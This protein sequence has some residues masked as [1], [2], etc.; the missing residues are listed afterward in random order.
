MDDLDKY[1][2]EQKK[3]PEFAEIWE[4]DQFEY[5]L[6]CML[7]AARNEQDMSQTELAKKSGIRQS[8]ISRIEQGATVPSL[9]TLNRLA[10]GL[11][12]KLQISFV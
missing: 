5:D 3:D 2:T 11:G 6:T 1:L 8:N 7:I 10:Y 12:K 4:A 9:R